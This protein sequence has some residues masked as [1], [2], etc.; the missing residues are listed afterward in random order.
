M[1]MQILSID[2]GESSKVLFEDDSEFLS[3]GAELY[4]SKKGLLAIK[5]AL[6]ISKHVN[7]FI[8]DVA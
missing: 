2:V 4:I 5:G 1:K 8:S 7:R 6:P 3:I